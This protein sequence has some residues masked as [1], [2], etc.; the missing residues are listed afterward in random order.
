MYWLFFFHSFLVVL[1][2]FVYAVPPHFVPR[3]LFFTFFEGVEF[4][5]SSVGRQMWY[6]LKKSCTQT[7]L[8]S[9]MLI[10]LSARDDG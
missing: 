4:H 8:Y 9:F 5:F 7:R 3:V 10:M 1:S 6:L 2:L